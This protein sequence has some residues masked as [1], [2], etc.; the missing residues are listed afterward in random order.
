MSGAQ[1]T[2]EGADGFLR[3]YLRNACDVEVLRDGLGQRYEFSQLSYKPYPCCRFNHSAI[4]A[5]L[6]LRD[7]ADGRMDGVMRVRVGLN[8]QAYEAVCTPIEMRKAPRTNVQ[9]QFSI[10]YTVAAALVDGSVGLTH[11]SEASLQRQ[12]I[13]AMAQKVEPYIDDDIERD[14]GR[15]VSPASVA[16]EMED[17]QTHRVRVDIP[18]GH[19]SRPMSEADFDAKAQDCFRTAARPLHDG[20]AAELRRLVDRIETLDDVRRLVGV[21]TPAS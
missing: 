12:D 19:P 20:A 17:G 15:N 9:A 10:P 3:V 7:A 11:F 2:F 13:R 4:G 21:L 6:A 16:L 1:A 14:F 18:L 8:R 5:A